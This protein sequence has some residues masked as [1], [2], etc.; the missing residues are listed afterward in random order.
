M[1]SLNVALE[2]LEDVEN[3]VD[4]WFKGPAVDDE[5]DLALDALADGLDD[6]IDAEL[7]DEELIEETEAYLD[8]VEAIED[9]LAALDMELDVD[10][11][12]EG[13]VLPFPAVAPGS[14]GAVELKKPAGSVPFLDGL[15]SIS[16]HI[17]MNSRLQ[18]SG[19]ID[20][21]KRPISIPFLDAETGS[22]IL[23]LYGKKKKFGK[24]RTVVIHDA[25]IP[26]WAKLKVTGLQ[27]TVH[28]W[29]PEEDEQVIPE[30]KQ[31][32]YVFREEDLGKGKEGLESNVETVLVDKGCSRA[33]IAHIL[34]DAFDMDVGDISD[35]YI[36]QAMSGPPKTNKV[37]HFPLYAESLRVDDGTNL[38][39][40]KGWCPLTAVDPDAHAPMALREY[41]VLEHLEDDDVRVR[42]DVALGPIGRK[43]SKPLLVSVSLL[44]SIEADSV[45]DGMV[46]GR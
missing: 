8:A 29:Q 34:A 38:L 2:G 43:Y 28:G 37:P 32:I 20:P 39:G 36:G 10:L 45:M 46:M 16:D 40:Q 22:P 19:G 27:V 23:E 18:N 44:V 21:K 11:D 25:K 33:T 9:D 5:E 14:I 41:P 3:R 17:R 7:E 15:P 12:A 31:P 6:D 30:G 4:L 24:A 26:T 42:M 1:G 13:I 35:R